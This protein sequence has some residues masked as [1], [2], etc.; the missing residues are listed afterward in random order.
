MEDVAEAAEAMMRIMQS[1]TPSQENHIG[2]PISFGKNS[3]VEDDI[4]DLEDLL[5]DSEKG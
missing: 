1:D 3:D 2:S 5:N 4:Q